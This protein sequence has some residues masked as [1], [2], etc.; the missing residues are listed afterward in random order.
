[1]AQGKGSNRGGLAD[2]LGAVAA[3]ARGSLDSDRHA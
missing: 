3:T 2:A 1:M